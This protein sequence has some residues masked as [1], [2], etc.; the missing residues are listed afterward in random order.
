MRNWIR[1]ARFSSFSEFRFPSLSLFLCGLLGNSGREIEILGIANWNWYLA[2]TVLGR[3][4]RKLHCDVKHVLF[5]R[6]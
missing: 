4:C 5:Y 1:G 3:K 6:S 2:N